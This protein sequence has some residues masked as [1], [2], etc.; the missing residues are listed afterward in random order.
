MMLTTLQCTRIALYNE[1]QPVQKV[2]SVEIEK[3]WPRP[4]LNTETN[5]K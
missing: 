5:E 4:K 1:E 2:T 3:L